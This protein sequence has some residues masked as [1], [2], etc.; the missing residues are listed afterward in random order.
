V[1][2]D[3]GGTGIYTDFDSAI[4]PV[5]GDSARLAGLELSFTHHYASLP[6]PWDGLLTAMNLTLTDSDAR[7]RLTSR[8]LPLPNQ[9]D[10]LANLVIGYASAS[11]DLRVAGNY[12]SRRLVRLDEPQD[13]NFDV[14]EGGHFSLDVSAKLRLNDHWRV[15]FDAINLTD[16]PL[17][18]FYGDKQHLARFEDYG[19]TLQ[20]GFRCDL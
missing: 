6:A 20:I 19:R 7:L 11:F 10:H 18:E 3:L 17:Y 2:A 15:Q 5:N 14:Y 16:R 9:S 4:V 1:L 12:R 13:S 8:H